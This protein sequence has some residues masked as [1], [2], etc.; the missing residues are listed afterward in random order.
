MF[1]TILISTITALHVYV[2]WR[3]TSVPWLKRRFSA[4]V[5][6]G[7]GAVLWAGFFLGRTI[8]HHSTGPMA[9]AVE[10]AGMNWMGSLFLI[11]ITLL[12]MDCLTAFGFILPRLA[13]SLRG[14]ALAAGAALSIVAVGQGMR[15]PVISTY[16]VHLPSLP[17][18]MENTV[19]VALSDLHLG[20][21][22]GKRWM[23][24]RIAQVRD[25]K[26]DLIL[27]VGDLAEGHGGDQDA[28]MQTFGGLSAPLGVWGVYGNHEYHRRRHRNASDANQPPDNAGTNVPEGITFL[29]NRWTEISPG[30]VLAGVDDP[31]AWRRSRQ[32]GDRLDKALA[33][34]PVGGTILLSHRPE[35]A[36]EAARMGVGLMLCGHTHGGQIWPFDYLV[37]R[38]HPLL[39]GRYEVDAM[40]VIVSRGTGTWGPRM[41]LW[42]PGEILRIILHG[43]NNQPADG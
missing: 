28:L 31:R 4:K 10:L 29:R 38:V 21:L 43:A 24:K 30:L 36:E 11:F 39:E 3:A 1:G 12:L 22:I 9:A 42:A 17:A 14:W 33:G 40:T 23:E 20:S 37:R 7:A 5:I 16:H 13:P 26:P 8:E 35:Q 27:L 34:R 18:T 6:L 19:I 15:A 41:R 32:T 2:F 25:Q